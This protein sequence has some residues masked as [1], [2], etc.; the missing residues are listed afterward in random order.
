MAIH[1]SDLICREV[2]EAL[3]LQNARR[4]DLHFAVG[5]IVT[6]TVE[7]FPEHDGVKNLPAI[8]ARYEL[9]ERKD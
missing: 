9:V 1:T 3:G 4:L 5:E 8:L 6:A 7:Y 2:A